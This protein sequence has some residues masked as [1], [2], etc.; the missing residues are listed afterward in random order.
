MIDSYGRIVAV[1]L[2]LLTVFGAISALPAIALEPDSGSTYANP[3]APGATAEYRVTVVAGQ[4]DSVTR[5]GLKR[6]TLNYDAD[7]DF[8]GS[9]AGV[10]ARDVEV[11]I[12]P[13]DANGSVPAGPVDVSTNPAGDRLVITLTSAYRNVRPGSQISVRV[14][15]VRNTEIAIPDPQGLR[16]FALDVT[17]SDPQGNTDG[18]VEVRYTIDPNATAPNATESN[19][20]APNASASNTR[21]PDPAGGAST[22]TSTDTG[23]LTAVRAG[24]TDTA[25]ATETTTESA[26]ATEMT[27]GM[28][29]TTAAEA[30]T[31][32]AT[33]EAAMTT[34]AA[35]T[36]A[37]TTTETT[38]ETTTATAEATAT[39]TS[40]DAPAS[41]A[42]E[43]AGGGQATE[44]TGPGFG[45]LAAVIALLAVALLTRRRRD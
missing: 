2:V 38:T 7:P 24:A 33:T 34:G 37:A 32:R 9:V 27:A 15:N 35:T 16:G 30:T 25:T 44:T 10:T 3:P 12:T 43:T 20:S 40:T 8:S 21:T 1:S 41:T 6:V 26:T 17:T 19:V 39:E 45:L 23:T 11:R 29:T 36:E 4:N 5:N 18:P 28:T 31:T 13:P 42:A 14:D 22:S